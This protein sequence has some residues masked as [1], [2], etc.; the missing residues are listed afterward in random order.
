MGFVLNVLRVLARMGIC[1]LVIWR[2]GIFIFVVM[3]GVN[4]TFPLALI[5]RVAYLF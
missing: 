1:A 3:G 5:A 2:V 4:G